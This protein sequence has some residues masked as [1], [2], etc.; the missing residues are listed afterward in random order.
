MTA[1]DDGN[2]FRR[3]DGTLDPASAALAAYFVVLIVIVAVLLIV[4]ALP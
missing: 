3:Q 1:P 2:G 4:S